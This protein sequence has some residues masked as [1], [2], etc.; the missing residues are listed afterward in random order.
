MNMKHK[1]ANPHP[2]ILIILILF[3]IFA[4]TSHANAQ[5][6]KIDENIIDSI[7]EAGKDEAL[8]ILFKLFLK[9]G[10]TPTRNLE[11][12]REVFSEAITEDLAR[13][14]IR[15]QGLPNTSQTINTIIASYEANYK[16]ALCE[17]YNRPNALPITIANENYLH[18]RKALIERIETRPPPC[19]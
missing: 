11:T 5:Q 17:K 8:R 10:N 16:F 9:S 3:G 14:K 2:F 18:C 12:Y 4:L 13:V 1:Q 15:L 7:C 6:G 19:F